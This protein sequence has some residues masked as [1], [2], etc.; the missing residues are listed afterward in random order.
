[1]TAYRCLE[2]GEIS[3][4]AGDERLYECGVCGAV[5]SEADSGGRPNQCPECNVFAT[6]VADECCVA[7]QQGAVE[8]IECEIVDGEFVPVVAT[9]PDEL[10]LG[11]AGAAALFG[12]SEA[13]R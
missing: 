6:K 2:C 7:C 5:F 12:D 8:E 4:E 11:E 9:D 13:A 1:M 3:E 10:P